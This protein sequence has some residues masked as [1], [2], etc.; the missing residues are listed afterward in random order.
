MVLVQ[1][2]A[3]SP[4]VDSPATSVETAWAEVGE[5]LDLGYGLSRRPSETRREFAQR[6]TNDMRIPRQPIRE[7][8][9]LA[10]V[11]RYYPNGLSDSRARAC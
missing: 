3:P 7:L 4:D 11:A 9:E 1:T 2:T 8:A 6:L 5:T 10:T